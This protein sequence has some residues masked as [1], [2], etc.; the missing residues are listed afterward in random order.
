M[1]DL[2]GARLGI[3]LALLAA[4]HAA[5]ARAGEVVLQNDSVVDFG[6]AVIQAGFIADERGAA[7]LTSTCDG[8]VTAVR[9]LW[10]SNPPTGGTT[11]GQYVRVSLAGAF[12]TPGAMQRELAGP[13]M[14]EGAFNEFT[15]EPPLAIVT[16]QTIV[17]DFQ[18]LDSPPPSGPS[19]VTDT[20]GCQAGKNAVYA[21][22]GGWL[23]LCDFGVSG[24]LAIRAVVD[25]GGSNVVFADGFELGHTGNWSLTVP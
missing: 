17:V 10:L 12:P 24:D 3:A 9:I 25:C 21:I 2:L 1:R 22:P 6:T 5:P 8:D 20:D 16:G 4:A 15:L 18:F 11:L 7:W 13:L 14:T 23:N 19:L